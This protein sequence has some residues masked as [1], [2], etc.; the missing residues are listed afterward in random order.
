MTTSVYMYL[1]HPYSLFCTASY[2]NYTNNEIMK[3]RTIKQTEIQF[4]HDIC[5]FLQNVSFAQQFR[6]L[7]FA[8]TSKDVIDIVVDAYSEYS[9]FRISQHIFSLSRQSCL[10]HSSSTK[11]KKN[12]TEHALIECI[13]DTF[14]IIDYYVK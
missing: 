7:P 12:Q 5:S 4:H 2:I 13:H 1:L 3:P 8:K 11:T 10:H 14:S 9:I 6:F